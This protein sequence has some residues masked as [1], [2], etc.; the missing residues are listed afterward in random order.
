MTWGE[1]LHVSSEVS[2]SSYSSNVRVESH[3]SV[4]SRRFLS[5]FCESILRTNQQIVMETEL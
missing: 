4:I 5:I 2:D 1:G 3:G